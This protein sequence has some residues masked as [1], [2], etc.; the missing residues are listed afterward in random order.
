MQLFIAA[1]LRVRQA[2]YAALVRSLLR[3]KS[4][5]QTILNLWVSPTIIKGDNVDPV[6]AGKGKKRIS[7]FL[8]DVEKEFRCSMTRARLVA[9]SAGLKTQFESSLKDNQLCMLPSYNHL[10]PTGDECGTY[11]AL[12]VGGSTFRVALIELSGR[13]TPGEE[14]KIVRRTSFKINN[15]VR[16]LKGTSFFDWMAERIVETLSEQ[17]E[18]HETSRPLSMGLSWSFPV[19]YGLLYSHVEYQT[20]KAIGR[21]LFEVVYF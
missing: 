14:I 13:R 11:L 21:L 19:E 18:G 20:D 15:T 9:L 5:L 10:L 17:A 1:M 12:D 3:T 6:V 16:Q 4:L 7:D 8:K 2:F